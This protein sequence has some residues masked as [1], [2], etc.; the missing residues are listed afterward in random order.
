MMNPSPRARR[1][2]K[3][4]K[5]ILETSRDLVATGGI[6]ALTLG[7]VAKALDLTTAALYRYFPSKGALLSEVNRGAIQELRGMVARVQVGA[8]LDPLL[9]L[10][11]VIE[12]SIIGSQVR[13]DIFAL[14]NSTMADPRTLVENPQDA[15]HIPELI[16][17]LVDLRPMAEAASQSGA[18]RTGNAEDR[19]I[20]LVFS[21][22]GVL[23][24]DKLSRFRPS[25]SAANL[26]RSAGHDLL[27][28][29]GADRNRI[30][31]LQSRAKSL[32]RS[33]V[34]EFQ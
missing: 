28:G 15:V 21:L 30:E 24:L 6:D 26:A 2:E 25:L 22:L 10:M 18:I 20:T 3:T 29:W 8:R 32:A 5:R 16:G 19:V 31:A 11:S 14:I 1:R 7:R 27:V 33:A 4:L 34:L 23:Q 9:A 13:R 17:L 12:T